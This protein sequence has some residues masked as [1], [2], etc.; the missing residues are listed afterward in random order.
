MMTTSILPILITT[1]L[2]A[3]LANTCAPHLLK[4]SIQFKIEGP[5]EPDFEKVSEDHTAD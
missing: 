2:G 1:P 3:I 5:E 4:Q